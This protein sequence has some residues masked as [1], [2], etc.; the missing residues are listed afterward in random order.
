MLVFSVSC[1]SPSLCTPSLNANNIKV[2]NSNKTNSREILITPSFTSMFVRNG[3]Y[4][5]R[6][7]AQFSDLQKVN[8]ISNKWPKVR[9]LGV[10]VL[11]CLPSVII[12][13]L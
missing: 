1:T 9:V 4:R 5:E 8:I 11:Y 10:E 3:P 6:Y 13:E 12:Q 2:V 7:S